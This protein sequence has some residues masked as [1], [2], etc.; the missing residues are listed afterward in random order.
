ML[1]LLTKFVTALHRRGVFE[2]AQRIQAA[3]LPVLRE[4][5]ETADRGGYPA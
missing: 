1:F 4:F 3:Y 5:P 2:A